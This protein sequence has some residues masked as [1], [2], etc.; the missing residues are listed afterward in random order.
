MSYTRTTWADYSS[1]I[2]EIIAAEFALDGR[3]SQVLLHALDGCEG[4]VPKTFEFICDNPGLANWRL[5]AHPTHNWGFR[6]A[7]YRLGTI[8]N[9]PSGREIRING[10]L[11]RAWRLHCRF[12]DS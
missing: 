12:F 4:G 11:E 8:G 9:E 10:T 1:Q 3:D 6:I 5:K 2:A 7:D